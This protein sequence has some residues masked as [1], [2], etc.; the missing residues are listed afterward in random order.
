MMDIYRTFVQEMF[1]YKGGS[2]KYEP[3]EGAELRR[4]KHRG[5]HLSSLKAMTNIKF[6]TLLLSSAVINSCSANLIFPADRKE[7]SK[8]MVNYHCV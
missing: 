8:I 3:R 1:H 6:I 2:V 7:D 5:P 4:E